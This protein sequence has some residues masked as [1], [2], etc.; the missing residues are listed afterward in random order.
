MQGT[1]DGQTQRLKYVGSLM[2]QDTVS[3]QRA[4]QAVMKKLGWNSQRVEKWCQLAENELM[5]MDTKLWARIRYAWGRRRGADG[6]APSLPPSPKYSPELGSEAAHISPWPYYF[7]Y[8]TREQALREMQRRNEGK[9][10]TP[11]P[12]PDI[13]NAGARAP[14]PEEK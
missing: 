11:P 6:S 1:T 4:S 12:G 8:T 10:I 7:I 9:D 13:R 14:E 2:R 5:T 3:F